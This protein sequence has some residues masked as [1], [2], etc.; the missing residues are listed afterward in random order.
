MAPADAQLPAVAEGNVLTT[1]Q[2][3]RIED[4][5][6]SL[7]AG[8]RGPTLMEDTQFR[9]KIMHFDHER[10]PERVVHPRG[11][12]AHGYFQVYKPLTRYSKAAVFSD[13]SVKTPVFVRFSNVNGNLGTADTIRDARGFA[14]KFYTHEGVWDL[15]GNNIPVFFIQD[16]IKF[17]DLV[18]AFKPEPHNDIPQASTAHNNFWDFI[19]L[20]PESMHMIMWVMSDRGIPRS[21]RM[22]DGFGVHTF[23]LVNDQGKSTFVKFHWK[24][25]L[26]VHSLVWDEA[27]KLAGKDPDFHRR[28]L[29]EA[30]ENKTY[31]E[32]ELALQ[33]LPEEEADKA[34]F[35]ILDATKIWPEDQF[36]LQRVGKLTLNRN[37]DNFFTETEEVAF[38]PGHLVP[39]IDVTDDPLL[40]GRL[41][42]YL[43]TQ[44]NRFGTPNFTQLPINQP[45][46]PVNNFQQD[47]IMR[48]NNRPGRINYEPNS[49]DKVP[50]QVDAKKGG[51]VHYP[52]AVQGQKVRE[53]SK[54]F[55][56]HYTQA[57]LFYNSLSLP[58]QE[59]IGQA[60][61]F[62]LGKVS[63]V[64]IQKLML[65][66][67]SKVDGTL[68][69]MVGM[70][71]GFE[72]PKGPSASRAGKTKGL[73]Q[74][75][76]PRDSIKG[77][78]VAVL[79]GDGAAASDIK[80][81]E[82]ALKKE[83]ATMEI[84]APRLGELKGGVKVDKSLAIVDSVM[85]DAVYVPGGK[86]SVTTLLGDYEARHFV[87]DAYNHG[88][89]IAA[90]GEGQELLQAVGIKEASGVV[91]D[92]S[93]G[94]GKSFVEAIGRHRHW[95]RPKP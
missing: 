2:G 60:L 87:R 63:D 58:E 75:E 47:G 24:P 92:K 15:V 25:L 46:S 62:E 52:A 1:N 65:D 84:I 22:M 32:Y 85:Y 81:L 3:M 88:K 37:P 38:H 90:S 11:S 26:G 4:D 74:E 72:A 57:A 19:S 55:G 76:G 89:A 77:R 95:N 68:A 21:Y 50:S 71:L 45:K 40:Q 17:P 80:Q 94:A 44:L 69:S 86:E 64:K 29:W 79:A 41:F 16:A 91:T 30:I 53:R 54:T 70:K 35:D 9:E 13:P 23:R 18:H 56:D 20:S 51:Y 36:P 6:N 82:T 31:P 93:G 78:K 28:D 8:A 67:L 33:L 34:P 61:I 14:V 10:M 43:D 59:H 73:S 42:S 49:G 5:A 39:G 83:G 12:G 66:H 48:F 7:K 27:Q